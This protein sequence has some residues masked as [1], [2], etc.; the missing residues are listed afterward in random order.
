MHLLFYVM[1]SIDYCQ[2]WS[3]QRIVIQLV[4]IYEWK[5]QNV[6]FS[7]TIYKDNLML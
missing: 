3:V 2:D 6:S 5:S 1:K 4:K 7:G